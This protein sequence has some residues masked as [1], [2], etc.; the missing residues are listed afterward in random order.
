[1]LAGGWG[2]SLE[3]K[4]Y[5]KLTVTLAHLPGFGEVLLVGL[6][7]L[8]TLCLLLLLPLGR[9]RR[10]AVFDLVESGIAAS[11]FQHIHLCVFR[12]RQQRSRITDDALAS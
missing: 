6:E 11:P 12:Q 3:K 8:L 5:A 4:T 2:E 7:I 10:Y 1:L 9:A